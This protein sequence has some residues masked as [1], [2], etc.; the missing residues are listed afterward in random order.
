MFPVVI[1]GLFQW[2]VSPEFAYLL[3]AYL[4]IQ[5]LDANLLVSV[6]FRGHESAPDR[7]HHSRWCSGGLWASLG[8]FFAI[9]LATLVKAVVNAWPGSSQKV[10]DLEQ[11]MGTPRL[12]PDEATDSIQQG[13]QLTAVATGKRCIRRG[14]VAR[15]SR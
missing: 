14:R 2:G 6:A 8:V 13:I 9:P 1:V 3:I 12:P 4:V 7:D 10:S 11:G 5:A 15:I